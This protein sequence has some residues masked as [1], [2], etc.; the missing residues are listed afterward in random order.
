MDDDLNFKPLNLVHDSVYVSRVC[1][2][3]C[4]QTRRLCFTLLVVGGRCR[5]CIIENIIGLYF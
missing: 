3:I 1:L 2:F 5:D 4:G